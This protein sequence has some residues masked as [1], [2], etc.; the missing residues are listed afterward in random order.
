MPF[1][2][3]FGSLS[4]HNERVPSPKNRPPAWRRYGGWGVLAGSLA[5][6][7]GVVTG[8]VAPTPIAP[9]LILAGTFVLAA[10]LSFLGFGDRGSNGVVGASVPGRVG[11]GMLVAGWVFYG[12]MSVFAGAFGG[13]PLEF[14][15]LILLLVG[16]GGIL[17]AQVTRNAAV[18]PGTAAWILVVPVVLG[19]LLLVTS[20]IA[21]GLAG[22]F[23]LLTMAAYAVTGG[24]VLG[25]R[26]ASPG[27]G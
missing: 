3:T 4:R 10:G 27:M 18:L 26:G 23:V 19:I 21:G 15:I 8:F 9:V 13:A 14:G 6:L 5:V 24:L 22:V 11:F 20:I 1:D 2:A 7:A 12:L 25:V 16:I 17:A